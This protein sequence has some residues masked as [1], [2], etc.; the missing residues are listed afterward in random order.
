MKLRILNKDFKISRELLEDAFDLDSSLF[1]CYY[2]LG[3]S[4]ANESNEI[5]DSAINIEQDISIEQVGSLKNIFN[6]YPGRSPI[7]IMFRDN[8]L[9]AKI[10]IKDF[11]VDNCKE[12]RDE[13][14]K[15]VD[16]N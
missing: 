2:F 4:F 9:K 6:K 14:S 1:I 11:K 3:N 10:S 12:L 15:T 16:I 8:G 7:E 5:Y 13:V